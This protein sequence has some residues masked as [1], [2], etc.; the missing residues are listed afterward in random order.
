MQAPGLFLPRPPFEL[1]AE[2]QADFERLYQSTSLGGLVDYG[3]SYPKWQYLTYLCDTKDLVLHGSPNAEI[4][5]VEPRQARDVRAFS[6]QKA[7]YATTDGIWA[8]YFAILDR[9]TYPEMTLFNT[10]LRVRGSRGLFG[11]PMYFF[12]ITHSVLLQKPWCEGMIYI[13]PRQSFFQEAP[14]QVQEVEIVIPHW[15]SHALARPVARLCVGPQ[16]LPFL[17]KI[18]GHN[19]ERLVESY[20][21]DPNGFPW[22]EALES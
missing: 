15:I 16:D 19:N 12:S 14:Q 21:A 5:Q 2:K 17:D 22:P 1:T 6:D 4:G 7:I 20:R 8:I 9:R 10:C 11:E 3:L 18:H 13:L